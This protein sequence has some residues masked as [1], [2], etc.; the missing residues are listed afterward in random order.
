[1]KANDHTQADN[2][3]ELYSVGP[4]STLDPAN[5]LTELNRPLTN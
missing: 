4:Q 1:M 2:L 3:W 5:W